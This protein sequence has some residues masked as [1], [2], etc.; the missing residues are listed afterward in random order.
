MLSLEDF[1]EVL[2]VLVSS[3]NDCT[4]LVDS[5]Q[6]ISQTEGPTFIVEPGSFE[7]ITFQTCGIEFTNLGTGPEEYCWDELV[8]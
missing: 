7:L 4:V 1:S 8:G 3:V 5:T 2:M 6:V